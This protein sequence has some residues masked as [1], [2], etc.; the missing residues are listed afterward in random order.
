MHL[1]RNVKYPEA[2]ENR[3][4]AGMKSLHVLLAVHVKY[5]EAV[6]N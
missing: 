4:R 1:A 2:V 5:P 6:G 3:K